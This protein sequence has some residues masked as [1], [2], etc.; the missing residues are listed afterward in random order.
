MIRKKFSGGNAA[1]L[2]PSDRILKEIYRVFKTELMKKCDFMKRR[3]SEQS[4][5]DTKKSLYL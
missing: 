2:P 5:G 3:A 4:V 1:V